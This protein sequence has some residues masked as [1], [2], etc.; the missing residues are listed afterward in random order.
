MKFSKHPYKRS[1]IK[2]QKSDY[3]ILLDLQKRSSKI[4]EDFVSDPQLKM[5]Y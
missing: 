4:R 2:D 3:D 5:I 1:T